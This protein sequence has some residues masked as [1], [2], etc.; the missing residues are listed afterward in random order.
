M[1]REAA[2]RQ[3]REVLEEHPHL[4]LPIV[5]YVTRALEDRGID[6]AEYPE[7]VA[8]IA[9]ECAT[10]LVL[11]VVPLMEEVGTED[12]I[13]RVYKEELHKH[14][15]ARGR[16]DEEELEKAVADRMMQRYR[17]FFPPRTKREEP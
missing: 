12:E 1:N 10:K 3:A 6:P 5:N 4:E 11:N 2:R 7:Q 13:R 16:V 8:K 9:L 15:E 17:E 14:V